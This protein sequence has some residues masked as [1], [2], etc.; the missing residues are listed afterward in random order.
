MN[1]TPSSKTDSRPPGNGHRGWRP[2]VAALV[3][4]SVSWL[5]G[6]PQAA[7]EPLRLALSTSPLSLPF[8]VAEDQ[9]YFSGEGL[10]LQ[11]NEVI[12]GHRTLRQVLDGTADLATCSEAVVMFNS[13]E[14]RDY[15]V[16][17]TFVTSDDDIKVVAHADS[18]ISSARQLSGKRVGTVLAS[19]SHYYLDTL[20]LIN[21]V[22]PKSVQ[23]IGIQPEAM[24]DA[25]RQGDIDA[26]A[27]WEPFPFKILNSVPGAQL[28]PKSSSYIETFNLV[29]RKGL[30]ETRGDDLVK[31]LRALDRAQNFIKT[32]PATAQAILR[33][34]L[35]VEQSFID[36]IWPRNNYRL[37]LGQALLMTLEGEAR[38]ARQSGHVNADKSPNYLDFIDTVPLRQVRPAAISIH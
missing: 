3:L 14:R 24:A 10:S 26:V 22:D 2:L 18:G 35:H 37:T 20:L 30:R 34:R 23:I 6:L 29:A 1:D 25:L 12:G 9:G 33:Q 16:M 17:A 32:Q 19:A 7:A 38:W 21:G 15:A 31:L 27:I 13:F 4:A 5:A 11:I 36:W 28:L 8:F